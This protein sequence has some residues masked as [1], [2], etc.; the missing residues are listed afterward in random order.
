MLFDDITEPLE[1]TDIVVDQKTVHNK[2]AAIDSV[3]AMEEKKNQ[4]ISMAVQCEEDEYLSEV[5]I[6]SHIVTNKSVEL[7]YTNDCSLDTIIPLDCNPANIDVVP[8]ERKKEKNDNPSKNDISEET[9]TRR[10]G[11][12]VPRRSIF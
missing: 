2:I 12:R 8:I 6:K 10:C 9:F 5:T 1:P 4:N 3:E 7:E 11:A